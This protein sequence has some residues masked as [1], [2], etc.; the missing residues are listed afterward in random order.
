MKADKAKVAICIPTRGEMEVGTAFDLALMCGYDS[1]FRKKG[2]QSLYTVAGT[3]IFDQREKM[4]EC[5]I[6]RKST[7]LN[8]SHSQQS[9]MPSS[10]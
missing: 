10:A 8:S 4:A 1:R 9:R 5:A 7:R 6:D 3:L 2:H